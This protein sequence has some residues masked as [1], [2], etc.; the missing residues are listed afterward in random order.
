MISRGSKPAVD[1]TLT[2]IWAPNEQVSSAVSVGRH[3]KA[4]GGGLTLAYSSR[5]GFGAQGPDANSQ[6][7]IQATRQGLVDVIRLMH[8]GKVLITASQVETLF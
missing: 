3:R 5:I 7:S 8:G 6:S 2:W 1:I 4:P